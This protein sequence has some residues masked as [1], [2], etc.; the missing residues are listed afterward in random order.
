MWEI[1]GAYQLLIIYFLAYHGLEVGGFFG[2][3]FC[4]TGFFLPEFFKSRHL[5]MFLFAMEP[6]LCRN[7]FILLLIS[8]YS[9][10][11]G[12]PVPAVQHALQFI[13]IWLASATELSHAHMLHDM[14]CIIKW[15][16]NGCRHAV[17]RCCIC[18]WQRELGSW[19]VLL[20]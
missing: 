11:Q 13:I 12:F 10:F 14:C 4:S 5:L 8:L 15:E 6:Q 3:H 20:R 17:Y 7:F 16:Q 9:N 2:D 1:I 18:F 19:S